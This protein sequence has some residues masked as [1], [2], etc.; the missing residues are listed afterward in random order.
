MH[1]EYPNA[2]TQARYAACLGA[3]ACDVP[4]GASTPSAAWTISAR[5]GAAAL[6]RRW[7][8]QISGKIYYCCFSQSLLLHPVPCHWQAR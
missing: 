4:H 5:G 2:L 7:Q 8:P 1:V 3:R 6:W